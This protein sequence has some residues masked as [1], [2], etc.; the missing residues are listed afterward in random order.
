MPEHA[1]LRV[2]RG[3]ATDLADLRRA[4]EG[5]D[6]LLV[7]LGT[8]M[9]RKPT[10]LYTDFGRALLQLQPALGQIPVIVLTGFGAG[11]SAGYQGPLQA[12]ARAI[13]DRS[14]ACSFVSS[15]TPST[16]T[17]VRWRR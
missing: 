17:R 4:S 1:K 12:T 6:A 13:R 9:D 2:L 14:R 11:D 7:T 8:G 5:A 10:Q 16:P 3:S 15:C